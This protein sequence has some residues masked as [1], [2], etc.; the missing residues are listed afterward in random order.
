M[1]GTMTEDELQAIEARHRHDHAE[2]GGS[3]CPSCE[4]DVPALV[5]EVRRLQAIAEIALRPEIMYA[6]RAHEIARKHG[7]TATDDAI[8]KA[9]ATIACERAV[10]EALTEVG[11]NVT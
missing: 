11:V 4:A 9:A 10:R 2:D 8:S 3:A 7:D 1:V 5:A 6:T